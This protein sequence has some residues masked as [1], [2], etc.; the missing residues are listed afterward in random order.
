MQ[1]PQI[2]SEEQAKQGSGP[3]CPSTC[4]YTI[5][6]ANALVTCFLLATLGSASALRPR[7]GRKLGGAMGGS[8]EGLKITE[9]QKQPDAS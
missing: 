8:R 5:W 3:V 7:A 6:N 2:Y 1:L 9:P 4:H